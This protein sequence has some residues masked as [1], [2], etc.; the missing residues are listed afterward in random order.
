[1]ESLAGEIPPL[2]RRFDEAS[3]L[4]AI[5]NRYSKLRSILELQVKLLQDDIE[6][7][8]VLRSF[9]D[10][11]Y[12]D[13]HLL[14]AIYNIRL[15]IEMPNLGISLD[16]PPSRREMKEAEARIT[17]MPAPTSMFYTSSVIENALRIFDMTTL[18]TYGFE[19]RRQDYSFDVVQRFLRQRMKH[20]DLDLPHPPLF[21][22]PPGSWPEV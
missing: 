10:V 7:R 13:W 20:Y 19:C 16:S 8:V 12:K 22:K 3:S 2:H 6:S 11:G 1:M 17:Q 15:N 4:S 14:S 5:R 9:Y 18:R 21:G